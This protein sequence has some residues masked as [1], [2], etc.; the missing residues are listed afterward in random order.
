MIISCVHQKVIYLVIFLK[1]SVYQIVHVL[2]FLKE[3]KPVQRHLCTRTIREKN[4]S[5]NI[6]MKLMYYWYLLHYRILGIIVLRYHLSLKLSKPKN[7][8][9][10]IIR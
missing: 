5:R 6:S 2:C 8:V 9:R 3:M 7:D 10:K 4:R 1:C